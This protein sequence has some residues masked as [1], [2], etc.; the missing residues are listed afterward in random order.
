MRE[1]NRKGIIL[2]GGAGTRLYPSTQVLSKQL[3]PVFDKP[4]VYYP[5]STLMLA[6]IRE[7]L[8]ISTPEHLPMFKQLLGDG[9]KWGLNLSYEVQ[10]FPGGLA[11][12]FQ[13]G[14]E[15]LQGSPCALILGDNIFHAN[16]IGAI[17]QRADSAGSGAR[18]FAYQV[19]DPKRFGIVNFDRRLNI[20]DIEEKPELPSS[21]FAVTGLY[22][23][24]S[25]VCD[26]V[27]Q[28]KPSRRGE[29]EIT[30]LNKLY[31]KRNELSVEVLGRGCA[32]L[33]TG[34][35]DS[36]LEAGNFISVLQNRQGLIIGC[37][38]E[39]AFN[40]G[41]ITTDELKMLSEAAPSDQYRSYLERLINN[42]QD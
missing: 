2:A 8:V 9:S 6:G 10:E 41:W 37:P 39:I 15:F 4:M 28:I 29:L 30:D 35:H 26:L 32:W 36:L 25:N 23:Y 3:L 42:S 38:E 1:A 27:N 19:K 24:D 5:L 21:N 11:Q 17:L 22:F 20:I 33:D 31:L 7:I 40:N 16:D 14:E 12:A 18:I 13:I 34:T